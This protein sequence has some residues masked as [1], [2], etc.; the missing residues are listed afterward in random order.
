M[1][2]IKTILEI[3]FFVLIWLAGLYLWGSVRG[4]R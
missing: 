2:I 3:L 1:E 4:R